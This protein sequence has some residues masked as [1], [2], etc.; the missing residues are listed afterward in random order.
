MS[1]VYGGVDDGEAEI[2]EA[3]FAFAAVAGDPRRAVDDGLTPADEAVE[4]G[5]LAHVGAADDRHG[6]GHGPG[7]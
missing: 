7:P 6:E 3:P 1:R 4:Q 2:A 5:R